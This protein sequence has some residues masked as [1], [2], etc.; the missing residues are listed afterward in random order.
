MFFLGYGSALDFGR[1]Y[2]MRKLHCYEHQ[3]SK[4]VLTIKGYLFKYCIEEI[5]G[6][7]VEVTNGERGR[8]GFLASSMACFEITTETP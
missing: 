6:N 8:E 2:R 1:M 3:K 7:G 5:R 4:N